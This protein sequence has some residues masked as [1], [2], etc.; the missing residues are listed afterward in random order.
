MPWLRGFSSN[1]HT[2]LS[3]PRD[4]FLWR[5]ATNTTANGK[6]PRGV[7]GDTR[8]TR[9]QGTP[10]GAK[11]ERCEG[12]SGRRQG[13]LHHLREERGEGRTER[14]LAPCGGIKWPIRSAPH[15]A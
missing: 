11:A 9:V 7:E 8:G 15:F 5:A 13:A 1:H 4:W 10:P 6:Q 12:G 14:W 3:P 2:T